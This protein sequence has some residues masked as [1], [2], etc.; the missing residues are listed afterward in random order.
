METGK[1]LLVEDDAL[2][3]M[4][5]QDILADAG[6]SVLEA[7]SADEGLIVLA[8][9][10]E[11]AILVTDVRMPGS[12]DG[13]GLTSIVSATRPDIRIIVTSGHVTPLKGDLPTGVVFLPKAY[14]PSALLEAVG[15]F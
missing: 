14:S 3:R 2:V 9:N 15:H 11:I 12:I 6:Y 4:V 13:L 8:A 5:A 7:A 1:L 10:P